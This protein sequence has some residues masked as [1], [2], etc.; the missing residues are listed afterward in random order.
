M[1]AG[2]VLSGCGLGDGSQIEE[3][4]LLYLALD[5]YNIDYI[6]FA[7]D[8]LQYDV[9]NHFTEEV[10]DEQRNILIESARIGRGRIMN[11]KKASVE[12]LDILIFPGGI[13]VFKNLSNYMLEKENFKLDEDVDNLIKEFY[14]LTFA[15]NEP[16]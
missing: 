2:I 4:M 15:R 7:P 16:Y 1:K 3:V 12:D 11:I 9:V 5:K 8:R 6:A 10:Q 14:N 13:G